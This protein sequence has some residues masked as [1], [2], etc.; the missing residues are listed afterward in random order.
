M[1]KILVGIVALAFSAG[2]SFGVAEAVPS[3][4]AQPKAGLPLCC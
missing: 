4:P 1:K 3:A 2:V